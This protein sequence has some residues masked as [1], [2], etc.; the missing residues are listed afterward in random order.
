VESFAITIQRKIGPSW[1]IVVELSG[2]KTPLPIRREGTLELDLEALATQGTARDYGTRLGQAL[3]RDRI[4]EAFLQART[5]SEDQLSVQLFVEAP[6]LHILR[7]ERLCAPVDEQWRFLLF[8]QRTPLTLALPSAADR[9]FPPLS[10]ADLRALVIVAS[11]QGLERYRLALFDVAATVSSVRTALGAIPCDVLSTPP[12]AIGPPTLDALCERLT[13]TSYTLLHIVCHGRY[14]SDIG[15]TVLYLENEEY[16]VDPVTASRLLDR[17]S[18]LRGERG[19]PHFVFL[20]TCE[21]ASLCT[22]RRG[23]G[24]TGSASGP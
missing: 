24:W 19:L 15:E 7:W 6:E 9:C 10:R 11:P 16:Q 18:Q 20:A 17:L 21:S 12:D 2:T 23:V 5:Q 22:S 8:D 14:S 1:P 13:S 4:R 3:F